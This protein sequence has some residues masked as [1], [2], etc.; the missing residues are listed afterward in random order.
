MPLNLRYARLLKRPFGILVAQKNVTRLKIAS[1]VE[2][3]KNVIA[4]GDATT[5]RLISFGIRP[6]IAVIDGME[7]RSKHKHSIHY[8]AKELYCVNPAGTI[9]V[10]A[11]HVLQEALHM[12]PPVK[13]NV[14]GEEDLL[15][16]PLFAMAAIGSVVL[17]GQPLEGLVLVHIT[18][19][20]Q[21]QAKEL[22]DRVCES[23]EL[24][25]SIDRFKRQQKETIQH[26]Y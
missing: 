20:K 12:P 7:R 24:L 3:T 1:M 19:E 15:A 5:R 9:S 26:R 17:Y 22:M 21:K 25:D 23:K 4:V 16:L 18:E 8:Q 11:V 10:E 13:V 2:G 6:H 14:R